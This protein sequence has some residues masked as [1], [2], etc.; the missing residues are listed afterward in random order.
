MKKTTSFS[1]TTAF[2]MLFTLPLNAQLFSI[3]AGGGLTQIMGPDS[4]KNEVSDGGFG[5]SSEYNYGVIAKLGLPL[6]PLTPRAF[7]LSHQLSGEGE[8]QSTPVTSLEYSQ[9][10]LSIGLGAQFQFI[11]VPAGFDPYFAVDLLYNNFS[12]FTTK[13]GG[14][15]TKNSGDSRFGAGVSLGSA[16]TIIPILNLD[17]M[18]SYQWLN[19]VGKEEVNNVSE[20]TISVITFDAFLMFSFL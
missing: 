4:Y 15:E 2:L 6:I 12:D 13:T 7:I 11:P 3:G 1:V 5:F 19:L 9:S 10:I 8:T 17:V 14:V 20:E 18:L 16:I